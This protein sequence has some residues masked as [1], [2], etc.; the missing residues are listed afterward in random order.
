[1][2]K[3]TFIL[4]LFVFA[5]FLFL[6]SC[7]STNQYSQTSD[8][9]NGTITGEAIGKIKIFLHDDNG[10]TGTKT[11]SGEITAKISSANQ[12][13]GGS[14][15]GRLSGTIKNKIVTGKIFGDVSVSDGDSP[16]AGNF[17]GELSESSGSGE[18]FVSAS[19]DLARFKG[20]WTLEKQ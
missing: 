13:G 19:L 20:K 12:Y 6:N 17:S 4:T 18:W 16:I 2:K 15:R 9:W 11:I 8:V 7:V 14:M 5:A 10:G 3:F 1:M